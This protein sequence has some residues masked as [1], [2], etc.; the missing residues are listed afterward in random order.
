MVETLFFLQHFQPDG[1]AQKI[2]FLQW[3]WSVRFWIT[4]PNM[5]KVVHT[6]SK[7]LKFFTWMRGACFWFSKSFGKSELVASMFDSVPPAYS[8]ILKQQIL[9]LF[10][11]LIKQRGILEWFLCLLWNPT[12]INEFASD[13]V[14]LLIQK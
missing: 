13:T 8:V 11:T 14:I 3:F 1:W 9:V 10:L 5:Q 4:S 7:I 2:E 12:K 6:S